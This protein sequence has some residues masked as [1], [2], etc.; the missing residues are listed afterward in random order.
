ML[1]PYIYTLDILSYFLYVLKV[2]SLLCVS[3]YFVNLS[4]FRMFFP[5]TFCVSLCIFW[6]IKLKKDNKTEHLTFRMNPE[7]LTFKSE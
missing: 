5:S 1:I 7:H 6:E 4:M 2:S 3:F